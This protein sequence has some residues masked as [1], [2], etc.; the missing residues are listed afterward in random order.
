MTNEEAIKRVTIIKIY[1]GMTIPVAMRDIEAIDMA[2][3]ALEEQERPTIRYT[4]ADGY[5]QGYIDGSTGTDWRMI[6]E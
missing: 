2:I 1:G 3:K 4:Y 6:E 5:L